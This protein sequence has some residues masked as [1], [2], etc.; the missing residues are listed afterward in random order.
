MT[1]LEPGKKMVDRD[2]AISS[3]RTVLTLSEAATLLACSVDDLLHKGA[4]GELR[5]CA[6]APEDTVVYSTNKGLIDLSDPTLTAIQRKLRADHAFDLL[7]LAAPEI[8]ML[9]LRKA[10]CGMAIALA[11]SL[12]A[13]FEAG[14]H[15]EP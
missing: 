11:K 12:Y 15:I 7:A 3:G 8:Q 1:K 13:K 2:I 5:I 4:R 10:D 6:R 14:N 9:V